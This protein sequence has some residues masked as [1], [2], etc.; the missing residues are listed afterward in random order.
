VCLI[1]VV[2]LLFGCLP[3]QVYPTLEQREISL[4]HGDLEAYGI[5]FITPSAATG[6]EEEKQAI[7]MVFAEV[8]RTERSGIRVV[9]LA[10][11]L[12]AVNKA[13][14]ADQYSRMYH[15][16]RD[17]GLLSRDILRQVGEVTS[18]RYVA[19]IKIQSFGQ[20]EKERLGILG[21]RI[22]ETKT[23]GLRLFF[24]IWDSRDGAVAWEATQEIHYAY[25]SVTEEPLTLPM[26][27]RRAAKEL[28]ATLP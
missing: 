18:V 21:L 20:S 2:W 28:V 14:L 7:A 3:A 17:T 19:Q 22:M 13:G 10:E 5:S 26:V 4:K 25:D 24:Q 16:Y 6:H 23:A 27:V 11:T 12:S 9:P 1:S 8:L 15:D